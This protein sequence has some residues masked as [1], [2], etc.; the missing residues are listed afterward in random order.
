MLVDPQKRSRYDRD[1]IRQLQQSYPGRTGAPAGH[2]GS[3][4]GSRPA[5][6]LSKRR[7]TFRGPPPSFYA[8]GGYGTT[9]HTGPRPDPSSSRPNTGDRSNVNEE[10]TGPRPFTDQPLNGEFNPEPT[11]RTQAAEDSRRLSRR[12]QQLAEAQAYAAAHDFWA[13]VLV[14]V[15]IL[16]GAGAV[17]GILAG[18]VTKAEGMAEHGK[19]RNVGGF[20]R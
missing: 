16:V 15:G 3:Y 18:G 10:S 6:G 12:Q 2:T 19:Q 8:Q 11:R 13:R 4:A 7:G 20:G 14:V 1:V 5:S 9:S 17:G